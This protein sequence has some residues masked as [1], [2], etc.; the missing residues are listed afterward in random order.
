M[1]NENDKVKKLHTLTNTTYSWNPLETYMIQ[2]LKKLIFF[3]N[4]SKENCNR[5]LFK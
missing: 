2:T 1:N 4:Q 5:V 3:I